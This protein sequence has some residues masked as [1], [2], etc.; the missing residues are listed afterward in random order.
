[1]NEAEILQRTL[2]TVSIM[3]GAGALLV[4][5]LG[6]FNLKRIAGGE[7]GARYIGWL[8]LTPI[9]LL[10]LFT[11]I[12][13]GAAMVLISM[14][15]CNFEFSRA[16]KLFSGQRVFLHITGAVTLLVVLFK[17]TLFAAMPVLVFF[18]LT[19]VPILAND[20]ERLS[21]DVRVMAY[22]Y[23]YIIWS[24]AHAVLML[25]LP[26]GRGLLLVVIV[27]CALADI[28][29][30]VVGKQ[31]GRTV[32]AP[33]INP[34]KAYEGILGDLLGA[35]IAVLLFRYIIPV[36]DWPTLLLLVVLIGVGSSWGDIISSMVKR[37]NDIKDWGSIVPGHGGVLD[38]L[39]SLIVVMPLVYYA[40]VLVLPAGSVG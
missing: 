1:V 7:L 24:L 32:I 3:F 29:A 39:N 23:M 35:V 28:G 34:R 19:L 40:L 31:I 26:D 5:M 6:R 4:L 25:D 11:D 2:L 36:Y 27:G 33:A 37:R 10:A 13:V 20:L 30:Y 16:T 21:G 15:L 14:M 22:G 17:P 38:R 8:V 12:R 9:Y 18:V